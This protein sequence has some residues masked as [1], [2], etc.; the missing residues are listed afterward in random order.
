MGKQSEGTL[1][2]TLALAP[3]D[4]HCAARASGKGDIAQSATFVAPVERSLI[5]REFRCRTD[6]FVLGSANQSVTS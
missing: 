2:G 4:T 6:T 1:D 3:D 5:S